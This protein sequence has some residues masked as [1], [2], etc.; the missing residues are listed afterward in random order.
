TA[1]WRDGGLTGELL[2]KRIVEGMPQH[3]RPGGTFC[4]VTLGLDTEAGP[5]EERARVWLKD[6]SNEFDVVFASTN[7]RTPQEVLKELC[8]RNEKLGIEG[9]KRI[10]EAF[11]KAGVK[12]LPYGALVMRRHARSAE[13]EPWTLRTALSEET[14][15][16]DFEATFVL[17]QRLLDQ[18]FREEL[19]DLKLQLAP[20]LQVRVTYVVHEG[21]LLPV[22]H[23]FETD[24]P[25][26]A[27]GRMDGWMVPLIARFAGGRSPKEIYNQAQIDRELPDGFEFVD[28]M[29]LV[30]RLLER[31][32]LTRVHT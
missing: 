31:G 26:I 25:F 3:L 22:E 16:T 17:H 10:E 21:A 20:R 2:V 14:K 9:A 13:Q 8:E 23:I 30:T 5:F 18:T 11:N 28:F 29:D 19:V 24:K 27:R 6:K 7:E 1:I 4:L 32:F 15:G 12:K